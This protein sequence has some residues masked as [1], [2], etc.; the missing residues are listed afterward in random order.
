MQTFVEFVDKKKR[1]SKKQLKIVKKLLESNHLKVADHTNDEEP[2]I[3]L[4]SPEK[5]LTFDGIRIYKIGSEMAFRIQKDENTHP[6]GQAYPL[7]LE[8]MFN[9]LMSD[10]RNP[11]KAGK[12]VIES[13][14]FEVKKFFSKS[15]EA[16]K[17]LR[18]EFDSPDGKV[19]VRSGMLDYSNMV[20]RAF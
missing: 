18:S 15:A 13:V 7:N 3:F 12:E 14:I 2:Y 1:E 6:F 19:A 10:H 4:F 20:G 16:E 17:D 9:D 11:E 5:D 8:E